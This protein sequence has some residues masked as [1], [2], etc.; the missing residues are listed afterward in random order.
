M[1][2]ADVIQVWGD[3]VESSAHVDRAVAD[4]RRDTSGDR[5]G[6]RITL[7]R[8]RLARMRRSTSP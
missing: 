3:R 4:Q 2:R 5:G 8:S 6:D 7:A 1:M